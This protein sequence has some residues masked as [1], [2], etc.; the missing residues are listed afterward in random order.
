[1]NRLRFLACAI[2]FTFC[3]SLFGLTPPDGCEYDKECVVELPGAMCAD[4]TSSYYT[5]IARKQSE[6]LLIFLNGGGACWDPATCMK[7]YA[8]NL[9]RR[10]PI[11]DWNT[12]TGIRNSKD[13]LNPFANFSVLSVPYCTGDLFMG[14]AVNNYGTKEKP[15]IV[16]HHGYR[17]V[18]LALEAAA[19]HFPRPDKVALVGMSA[20]AIGAFHHLS[21]FDK[22]F[23]SS[24]KY[25]ISDAGTPFKP[26]HLLENNYRALLAVWNVK[27][28]FPNNPLGRPIEHFGDLLEYNKRS[29]PNVRYGLIQAYSDYIMTFFAYRIGSRDP[30]NAVKGSAIDVAD[31]YL[32]PD[33]LNDRVFFVDSWAHTL[34][35]GDLAKT[36]SVGVSLNDWLTNM[37]SDLSWNNHRPDLAVAD[38]VAW[39]PTAKPPQFMRFNDVLPTASGAE[40]VLGIASPEFFGF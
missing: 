17:N 29:F 31:H 23:P 7:G 10:A 19:Q 14:D 38:G 26:P 3:I 39:K 12:G 1:M 18:E 2:G 28:N 34:T 16:R 32:G 36:K 15:F 25:V 22:H 30:F 27:I 6:N 13:P 5:V 21:S 20:G 35:D 40:Q 37:V 24:S 33:A 4:G 9:T 8:V 11:V